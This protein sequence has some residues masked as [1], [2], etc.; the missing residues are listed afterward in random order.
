MRINLAGTDFDIRIQE[1]TVTTVDIMKGG[2]VLSR[3]LAFMNPKDVREGKVNPI[4][5]VAVAAKRAADRLIPGRLGQIILRNDILGAFQD[6]LARDKQRMQNAFDN[7]VARLARA[8][9]VARARRQKQVESVTYP[10]IPLG[11]PY[12]I[13]ARSGRMR[14][15]VAG[16]LGLPVKSR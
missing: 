9:R 2:K 16:L 5:G 7:R 6:K 3:G 1:R 13:P 14:A 11:L 10:Y 12:D 4:D 15:F 8:A